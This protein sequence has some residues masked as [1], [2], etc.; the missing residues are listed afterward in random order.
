MSPA[1][2]IEGAISALRSGAADYIL[3]PVNADALRA[4]VR[5]VIQRQRDEQ[6]IARLSDGLAQSEVRYRSLFEN[7]LDGLLI[8]DN[9]QR[10]VDV[11]PAA[12]SML[13][14]DS[15]ADGKMRLDSLTLRAE[16]HARQAAR[17]DFLGAGRSSGEYS[18]ILPDG[19][20]IEIEYRAVEDC[21][22]RLHLISLRNVTARKHAEE[23]ARQSERLAAIGETM[24]ALVHESRNALQ[25]SKASLEM[26][27]LEVEDRPGNQTGQPRRKGPGRPT[28]ALRRSS[29]MGRAAPSPPGVM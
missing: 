21:A 17:S 25:R 1:A 3:K 2:D 8:L 9:D 12:R 20:S 13:G 19:A 29:G 28:P 24:A 16:G 7:T 22:P 14:W 4:S 5:R 23:R 10:V 15:S 11:N 27:K 26:L 6:E 18:F